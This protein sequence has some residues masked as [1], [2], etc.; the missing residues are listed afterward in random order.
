MSR[1]RET[2]DRISKQVR[3]DQASETPGLLPALTEGTRVRTDI[4]TLVAIAGILIWGTLQWAAWRSSE[5]VGEANAA[6]LKIQGEQLAKIQVDIVRIVDRIAWLPARPTPPA[7]FPDLTQ[8]A[9]DK[10]SRHG[11]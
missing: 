1:T 4:K 2:T 8:T 5:S 3:E 6:A 10:V 9:T 11:P 7:D